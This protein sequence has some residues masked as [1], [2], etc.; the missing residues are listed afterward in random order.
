MGWHDERFVKADGKIKCSCAVCGENYW[1][2]PSKSE[3]YLT[4]GTSC[5]KKRLEILNKKRERTC[6]TCGKLFYPRWTQINKGIGVY[7]SQKCNKAAHEAINT[8]ESR[9]KSTEGFKRAIEEGRYVP[10][11]GEKSH[12]W[13]GGQKAIRR[14]LIKS[15]VLAARVKD[16]RSRNPHKAR[17]FSKNRKERKLGR[18]P[19]GTIK[20]IG[21]CQKWKCAICNRGIIE[22]YHVDH[23]Y[24]LAKGGAHEV[25]N[26]QLLCPSCNV[27]KSAKDPIDYMQEMVFLL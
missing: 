8:E 20:K 13:K 18:L 12:V 24:P 27:R 9:R 17:E 22:K 1:L 7:C 21:E 26:I 15:G 10:P 3:K 25:S 4:C 16:Y 6:V 5:S 11:S 19:R 2:P 23:I 14:A